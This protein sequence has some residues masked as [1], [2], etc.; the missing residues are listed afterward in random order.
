M[1]VRHRIH[2]KILL[3]TFKALNGMA[4]AYI[5]DL[6][7]VRR[8]TLFTTLQFRHYPITS[9]RENEKNLLVIDV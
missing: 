1:A 5:S 8:Y 3:L 9:S 7:Y 6:I 2:S 4:P